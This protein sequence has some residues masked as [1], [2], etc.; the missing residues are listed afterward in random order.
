MRVIAEYDDSEQGSELKRIFFTIELDGA[1]DIEEI[2]YVDIM[3]SKECRV[4]YAMQNEDGSTVYGAERTYPDYEYD[5]AAA[6]AMA[7]REYEKKHGKISWGK[8]DTQY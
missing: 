2:L 1:A 4:V 3:V 7:V 5:E 8:M 6:E